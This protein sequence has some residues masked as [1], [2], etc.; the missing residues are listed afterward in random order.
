MKWHIVL[1]LGVHRSESTNLPFGNPHHP[2]ATI[3]NDLEEQ[4]H[5]VLVYCNTLD[6]S[7]MFHGNL[8]LM[9][10]ELSHLASSKHSFD[11]GPKV[12]GQSFT[13]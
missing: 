6:L 4:E 2:L 13:S 3:L 5:L 9:S 11:T 12:N 7:K 1:R 8:Q 10:Y